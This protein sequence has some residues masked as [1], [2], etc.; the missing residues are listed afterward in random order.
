M[1]AEAKKVLNTEAYW[2][3]LFSR[4]GIVLNKEED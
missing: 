1:K 4:Y 2:S 3:Y